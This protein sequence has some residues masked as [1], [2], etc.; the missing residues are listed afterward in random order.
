MIPII[1]IVGSS[2]SGKTTLIERLI[3]EFIISKL[4][5]ILAKA[6]KSIFLKLYGSNV[7]QAG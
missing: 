4:Q 5:G 6:Y 7:S 1:S 2:K 3:P